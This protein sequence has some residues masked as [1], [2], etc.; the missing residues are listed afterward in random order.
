MQLARTRTSLHIQ[1]A[2]RYEHTQSHS[3]KYIQLPIKINDEESSFS[4]PNL[5][6]ALPTVVGEYC[7]PASDHKKLAC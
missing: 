3:Y 1:H 5:S 2:H 7:E 6:T 4:T